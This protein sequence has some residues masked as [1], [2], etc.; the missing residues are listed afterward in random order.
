[1]ETNI[2]KETWYTAHTIDTKKMTCT[3]CKWIKT[4]LTKQKSFDNFFV[5]YLEYLNCFLM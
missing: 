1:M 3:F 5:D 4:D 2:V